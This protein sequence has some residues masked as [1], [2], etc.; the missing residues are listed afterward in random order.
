M[1]KETCLPKVRV[2]IPYTKTRFPNI[3]IFFLKPQAGS[4]PAFSNNGMHKAVNRKCERW[5]VCILTRWRKQINPL[6]CEKHWEIFGS[7]IWVFFPFY[8]IFGVNLLQGCRRFVFGGWT[9]YVTFLRFFFLLHQEWL[10]VTWNCSGFVCY[11]NESQKADIFT[12]RRDKPKKNSAKCPL[13]CN[14]RWFF[15]FWNFVSLL[16]WFLKKKESMDNHHKRI[17]LFDF[18]SQV[19]QKSPSPSPK[20]KTWVPLV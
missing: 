6:N 19:I 14:F 11:F 2:V 17:D 12:P 15:S 7:L 5:F 1:K 3:N 18:T 10:G 9:F 4:P 16:I 8:I 20:W 13:S